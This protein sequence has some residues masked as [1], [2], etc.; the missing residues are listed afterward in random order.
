MSSATNVPVKQEYS[1][2]LRA[3]LWQ[4]LPLFLIC[5]LMLDS[6]RTLR[7][8]LIAMLGYWLFTMVCLARG[9]RQ[10]DRMGLWF[11]RWGFVPLFAVIFGLNEWMHPLV[12]R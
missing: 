7:V 2:A 5:L 9:H 12:T 4:Q 10:P 11:V 6:G 8:C 1:K 3:S